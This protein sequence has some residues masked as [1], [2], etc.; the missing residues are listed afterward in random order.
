MVTRIACVR[1]AAKSVVAVLIGTMLAA[2]L[3]ITAMVLGSAFAA[4]KQQQDAKDPDARVDQI[5][6]VRASSAL[7]MYYFRP[8]IVRIP[9]GGMV[10]FKHTVGDHTVISVPTMMPKGAEKIK[11]AHRSTADV[12]FKL[13]GIYGFICAIHGRFG[14]AMIV[15]VGEEWPNLEEVRAG[16]PGGHGGD[17]LRALLAK[18]EKGG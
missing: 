8:G 5:V 14:M 1:G 18:L 6:N 15:T 12:T 9:V 4:D 2:L 10:R 17:R 7:E 16:I 13:P 3:L 11:L